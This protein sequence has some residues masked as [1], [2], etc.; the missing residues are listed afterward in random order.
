MISISDIHQ[1]AERL[2]GVAVRTPLLESPRLNDLVGGRILLKAEIFQNTGSFKF[3]GAY[4]R[5]SRLSADERARGIIAFSSGNH[6]QG[7]ARAAQMVGTSATILMPADAPKSKVEGTRSYGAEVVHYDRYTEDREEIGG[8]IASSRNLL[9]VPPFDDPH[10]IAG[11]GTCGLEITQQARALGA[12]IDQLFVCAGGGGLTSG[13]AIAM[14]DE[15]PDA[16]VYAVEPKGYDDI[17]LSLEKGEVVSVDP[18]QLSIADALLPPRPGKLTWPLMKR[19]VTGGLVVSDEEI[20]KAVAYAFHSLKLQV[21]PGGAA[22]LAAVLAHKIDVKDKTTAVTLSG[23]NM[24][25]QT[26]IEI[27]S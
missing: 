17:T 22:A 26:F 4:N 1:A 11:Q 10:I 9:L 5:I 14:N 7:V 8:E 15:M 18:S 20:C 12:S 6:A 25:I 16:K 3:R 2:A 13:C 19:Y 24:D 21:E 23:G 27:V